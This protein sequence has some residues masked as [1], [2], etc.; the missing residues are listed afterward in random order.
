MISSSTRLS[1][2]SP[3]LVHAEDM[4]PDLLVLSLNALVRSTCP[5]NTRCKAL[6]PGPAFEPECETLSPLSGGSSSTWETICILKEGGIPGINRSAKAFRTVDFPHPFLLISFVR[7]CREK[8]D[9][10]IN[11]YFTPFLSRILASTRISLSPTE[12]L[13]SLRSTSEASL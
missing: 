5:S 11:P 8:T 9:L 6:W 1:V 13:T 2:L 12:I 10:P 7:T 4:R 3:C